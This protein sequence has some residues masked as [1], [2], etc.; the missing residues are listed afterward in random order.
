MREE[1]RPGDAFAGHVIEDEVGRGGMGIVF[2][3]RN[4]ALDR[5]R[6]I[7]VVAPA[8]SADPAFAA[9]FRREAR[10]AASVEHPNVVTVHHAGDEDGLLYIVM[11]YVDGVDLARVLADGPVSAERA[12]SILRP[13]AAALDAAHAAGLVHRDV[14]PANVLLEDSPGGERVYLTDFGISKPLEAARPAGSTATTALTMSGQVLGTAD[15][16]SPEA[17]EGEDV[18]A[19]SDVYSLA[20]LAYHL[21]SGGPPF[22]RERE[23]ATLIAHTKAPRPSAVAA[24]P[25]LPPAVD[26]A[27]RDG[28]AIDPADR[29]GSAGEL[30]ERLGVAVGVAEASHRRRRAL[31]AGGLAALALA[32]ALIAG[33]ALGGGDDGDEEAPPLVETGEVGAGPVGVAV[34]DQRI[35]VAS[36]DADQLWR[37]RRDSPVK[38]KKPIPI[39]EP[40]AVAVGLGSVWIVNEQSLFELDTSVGK[41]VPIAV[42][43]GPGDVAVDNDY[44]W[45]SNEDDDTVTRVDPFSDPPETTT[46]DVGDEPRSIASDDGEVWVAC[47]GDGTVQRI[48]REEAEVTKTVEAGTRPSSLAIGTGSVWVIDNDEELLRRIDRDTTAVEGSPIAVAPKPRGVAVGFA[49][50]WVAGG[51]AE[52]V[53]ERFDPETGARIGEPVAVGADP[54]DVAIGEAAVYTANFG[55]A[56]VSRFEPEG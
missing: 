27:L 15:Y 46:I 23:L 17:I 16:V 3:A 30:V 50:V 35:W 26:A 40:R 47:A 4:V 9:R 37:L 12:M 38:A 10:L 25:A 20:C 2:R 18:D 28:M 36:R 8:L 11:R 56:T 41:P 42:G 55:D 34:G 51:G 39:L 6:A 7:K 31:L 1:P 52:G 44:V 22:P 53:V 33:L 19:R 54:A 21:L 24:N 43:D 29:P 49:S 45:V 5:L 32:A 48:S 14:K 13:V